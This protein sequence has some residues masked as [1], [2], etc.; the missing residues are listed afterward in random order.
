MKLIIS[1]LFIL[2]ISSVC[3]AQETITFKSKDGLVITADLYLEFS[4]APLIIL[5][6]QAGYSR[7]EYIEAAAKF[8]IW[9]FMCLAIDQ[10]SGNAVNGVVNETNAEAVRKGLPTT[11]LDAEQDIV[12]AVDFAF[13]HLSKDIFIMGSS[14]SASL[15]LKIANEDKRIKAVMSFS[16]GEYFKGKLNVTEAAAG[17][18]KPVF[19]TSS[20][21]EAGD[22][23]GVLRMIP[24]S[25]QKVHF[26]PKGNGVHGTK[27]L[28]QS[29]DNNVEYW[30]AL[31]KFLVPLK[32]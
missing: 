8:N 13:E 19:A 15:V 14:Y 23:S 11:Y 30:D 26:I 32:G 6:H 9:G 16:P 17:L 5:C 12:A 4:D 22:V 3:L 20:K 18:S 1:L 28:W 7:G 10:R 27:A 2:E 24:D 31:K 21:R 29:N 25:N